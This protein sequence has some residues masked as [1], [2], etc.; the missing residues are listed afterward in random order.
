MK[1]ILLAAIITLILGVLWGGYFLSDIFLE[2]FRAGTESQN[3]VIQP[4][5]GVNQVSAKLYQAK[6]INSKFNFELYLWLLRRG[7]KI[8]A[9]EY[10]L[11]SNLS[12]R[13]LV[14]MLTYGWGSNERRITLVEGWNNQQIGDYLIKNLFTYRGIGATAVNYLDD[15][16]KAVQKDYDYDFLASKPES[17]D[18]EGYLFPDTYDFYTDAEPQ[19]VVEKMLDNFGQ[20]LSPGLRQEINQQKRTIHEIVTLA[21]IVE[22]EVSIESDRR[23]VADIL[24]RRLTIGMPLQTDSTVN[25]VTGKNMAAVSA[26]D[27]KVDS[28]YNTYKYKGLPPGP[29]CNPGLVAI[30][31]AIEPIANDYWYF[32]TTPEGN[33]IYSKTLLEHNVAKAKYLK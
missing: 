19:A 10:Q 3:F 32:L 18:V 14:N 20:K 15:W 5:E 29:I 28:P 4:G 1:K 9:G 22:K 12:L 27:K 6:L 7:N 25:Y 33:V 11:K 13:G 8:Q 23:L 2:N 16:Q 17:V 30:Q 24:W 31:A 21:S 26:E